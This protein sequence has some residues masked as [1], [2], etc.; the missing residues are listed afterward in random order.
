[1]KKFI[2]S[3]IF[4]LTITSFVLVV[5]MA[6]VSPVYAQT[7]LQEGLEGIQIETQLPTYDVAHP[8]AV[9]QSGSSNLTSVLY[10]ILDFVKLLIGSIA[11]VTIIITGIQL[12]WARKK[13]DDVWSKQK[14][15]LIIIV[16]A[17]V[18]I[19]I[20]DVI[21]KNVFFGIQ[22]EVYESQAQAQAAA[23]EGTA[24]LRGVYNVGLMLAGTLAVLMIIL[25]GIK[26]LISGGNEE[27][28]TKTKKQITWLTIGLFLLGVAEFVV[29]DIIF[30]QAG[31]QI[32]DVEKGKML[33]INFT[34]FAAGF[35]VFASIISS[36][37]G[38]YVYVTAVGNEEKTGKAK[39]AITG[40]IIAMILAAGA[41]AIVSTVLQFKPGA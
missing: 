30:P 6:M 7:N 9:I 41:F 33:I 23:T 28:I 19:M 40:A 22:G 31:T 17:F 8:Q 25:A 4:V 14:D 26:L 11:V 12:I 35:V 18:I 34:N 27:V 5:R 24:Q 21:V 29:Q 15:K 36:I 1:M 10:Y 2:T 37:Y 3:L 39:K 20:A 38:G 16:T 13:V 32:P